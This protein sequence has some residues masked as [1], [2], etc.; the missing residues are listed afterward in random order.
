MCPAPDQLGRFAVWFASC[1]LRN[2]P[3][4][5]LLGLSRIGI[6]VVLEPEAKAPSG[7]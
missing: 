7:K 1:S 2:L 4:T 5:V 3:A 6:F